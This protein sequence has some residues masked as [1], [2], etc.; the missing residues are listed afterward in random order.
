M[1]A[2]MHRTY[3]RFRNETY[4]EI[5]CHNTHLKKDFIKELIGN[6]RITTGKLLKLY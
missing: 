6:L 3:A 5:F 1:N 2:G 4:K